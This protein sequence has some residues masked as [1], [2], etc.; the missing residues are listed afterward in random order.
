MKSTVIAALIGLLTFEDVQSIHITGEPF[1]ISQHAESVAKNAEVKGIQGKQDNR[2]TIRHQEPVEQVQ[3]VHAG[4]VRTNTD[5]LAY[6]RIKEEADILARKQAARPTKE[7]LDRIMNEKI[8]AEIKA[9]KEINDDII[10]SLNR[11]LEASAEANDI[12]WRNE[13]WNRVERQNA[14]NAGTY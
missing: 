2:A 12:R 3:N 14:W 10:E 9:R 6:D 5:K 7:E 11:R 13:Y 4:V 8:T 1:G